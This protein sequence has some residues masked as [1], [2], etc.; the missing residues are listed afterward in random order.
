MNIRPPIFALAFVGAAALA[1]APAFAQVKTQ[2]EAEHSAGEPGKIAPEQ[3]GGQKGDTQPAGMEPPHHNS[4]PTGDR[5][6]HAPIGAGPETMPAKFDETVAARDRIPIMARP[7]PLNDDQRRRLYDTIMRNAAAPVTPTEAA[8]ATILP[9]AVELSELPSGMAEEIPAVRGYK[10][11]K[12]Q[13]KI[14]LV[15]PANRVVVGEVSR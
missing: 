13:D 4:G 10:Y 5:T 9:S 3:K 6:A 7:L 11:V 14:L 15:A 1:G 12:L 2:S 8:P